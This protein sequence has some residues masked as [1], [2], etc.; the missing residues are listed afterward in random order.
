MLR[1]VIFAALFLLFGALPASS[2]SHHVGGGTTGSAQLNLG[3]GDF[4]PA[5]FINVL[6][7][8]V[9]GFS[10]ALY[11]G[12]IDDDGYLTSTP[13]GNVSFSFPSSGTMC[14]NTTYK[15]RWDSGVQFSAL[16]FNFV[17]ASCAA[18]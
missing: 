4:I 18:T 10:T 12:K 11:A 6:R 9:L 14:S 13:V 1:R 7:T 8:G 16:T 17:A 15:L 2:F 5:N 3:G